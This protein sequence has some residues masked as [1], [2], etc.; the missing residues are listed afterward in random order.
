MAAVTEK[1]AVEAALAQIDRAFGK[2]PHEA[3]DGPERVHMKVWMDPYTE[4]AVFNYIQDQVDSLLEDEDGCLPYH[5]SFWESIE[6]DLEAGRH[7]ILEYH[8][9]DRM[10]PPVTLREIIGLFIRR[11]MGR[12]QKSER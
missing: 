7:R 2:G 3:S 5:E 10:Y 12:F 8:P 4:R 1:Q 6:E 11:V 9:F